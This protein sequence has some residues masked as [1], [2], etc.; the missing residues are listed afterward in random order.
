MRKHISEAHALLFTT[1]YL[2]EID[3]PNMRLC[4][5][6]HEFRSTCPL[7]Y[8]SVE[9][10]EPNCKCFYS[11]IKSYLTHYTGA[12]KSSIKVVQLETSSMSIAA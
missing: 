4:F 7:L 11:Y 1:R 9:T 8:I 10:A 6:L 3:D 2:F 5:V 12:L